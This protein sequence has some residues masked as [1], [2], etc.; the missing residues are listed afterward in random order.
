M[1]HAKKGNEVSPV[2][3]IILSTLARHRLLALGILLSICG[4]ILTALVP[5]LVL[6][7][8]I[9]TLTLGTLPPL[10]LVLFYFIMLA[11]TGLLE[12][13][14][15]GL[16]TVCG[17]KITHALRSR[18]MGKFVRLSAEDL[19]RQEPGAVVS[20]FVGDVDTVEN[21]FTSGIIS[22]FAD[23]CKIISIL[24][25]VWFQT[26][27]LAL[28][29][30]LLLPLLF[31]FTRHVQKNMLAAQIEN[32]RAVS[33]ASAHV[34]ETLHNIRTI[35]TLGREDTYKNITANDTVLSFLKKH[36]K[37]GLLHQELLTL[38]GSFLFS[39]DDINK[40]IKVLS[41]GEM[42]RLS[43]LSA[44]TQCA[45]V[46][47]LDEPTNHLDFETVEALANSLKDYK[48]T[49]FFTSHDRTFTSLL[50][51]T[52]IEIKD[53]KI[54]LYSGDYEAY[55]YKAKLEA[56]KEEEE[57]IKFQNNNKN[58]ISENKN[59][60]EDRKKIRNRLS[61]CENLLKEYEKQIN[62][63]KNEEK[64]IL[65]FFEIST[66]YDEEKSKRLLEIKK[67]IEKTENDWLIIN[68]EIDD[69]KKLL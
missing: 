64:E 63:Y 59:S 61:K 42:A 66:N 13:A 16:L 22:M 35:H 69:I 60:Y 58:I 21:L 36:A 68:E 27:G 8:I 67:L 41:G 52:I 50:A 6:A 46:L 15:E 45:D 43:L 31:L 54:S 5:P 12:S 57:E 17:Q 29:F 2:C 26:K 18:L 7:R 4:A 10:F 40:D 14:R 34:P 56:L 51:D 32:R 11:L 39:G 33:R 49:I 25:V 3:Q 62:D 48:G 9:D 20:R 55:V 44:I 30:L 28:I 47:I 65:N 38:L 37:Q 19:N 53:K 24:V 23:A 1:Q